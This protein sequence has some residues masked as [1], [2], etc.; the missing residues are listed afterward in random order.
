MTIIPRDSDIIGAAALLAIVLVT[1]LVRALG[2]ESRAQA[3]LAEGL[4]RRCVGIAVRTATYVTVI[5][6]GADR[7]DL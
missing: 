1:G 3:A 7:S 6:A 2:L 5:L 4:G